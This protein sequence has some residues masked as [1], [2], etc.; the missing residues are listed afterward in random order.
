M[1]HFNPNRIHVGGGLSFARNSAGWEAL[2]RWL[3][4][5]KQPRSGRVAIGRTNG[6]SA[7][8]ARRREADIPDPDFARYC[9]E[10]Y[11]RRLRAKDKPL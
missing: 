10:R 11:E 5:I 2:C 7:S 9:R 8:L 1:R 3:F 6:H 4:E